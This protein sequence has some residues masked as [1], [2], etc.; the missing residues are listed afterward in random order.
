MKSFKPVLFSLLMILGVMLV[1]QNM[2]LFMYQ[3]SLRLNLLVW[4]RET[5]AIPLSVYF[6]TFFLVGLLVAYFYGLSERFKAKRTV[7]NHLVTIHKLE[8]E[9]KALKNLPVAEQTT[10]QQEGESP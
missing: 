9:V 2:E 4:S 5:G 3:K 8:E 6:L 7:K 1:V 10:P